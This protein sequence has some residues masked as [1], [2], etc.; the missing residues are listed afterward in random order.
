MRRACFLRAEDPARS[1]ETQPFQVIE[2]LAETQIDV[3]GH[4]LKEDARRPHLADDAGDVGPEVA[5]IVSA[6][7]PAGGAERLARVAR[8]ED[9]HASTPASAVEGAQIVPDRSVIQGRIRHPRHESGRSTGFP[10][11]ITH[12][13]GT[14]L[15]DPEGEVEA[16]GAG[17]ETEDGEVVGTTGGIW[18][19]IHGFPPIPAPPFQAG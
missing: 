16:A 3:V 7:A 17:T 9:I 2:D 19:H 11:D 10:F 4:V 8:S 12:S 18:S 14:G 15:G 1:D 6:S 13:S 5:G